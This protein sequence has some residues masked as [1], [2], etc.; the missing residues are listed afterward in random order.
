M[1]EFCEGLTLHF[2][3]A[4]KGEAGEHESGLASKHA[5]GAVLYRKVRLAMY[6]N[7]RQVLESSMSLLEWFLTVDPEGGCG[8]L[9]FS[10]T[11]A[12]LA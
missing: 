2:A 9:D 10:L 3:A 12:N 6:Q 4:E 1:S 5:F 11:W 7:V 8:I